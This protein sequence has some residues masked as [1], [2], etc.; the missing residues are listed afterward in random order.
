MRFDPRWI[1]GKTVRRR[2]EMKSVKGQTSGASIGFGLRKSLKLHGTD[3]DRLPESNP[4]ESSAMTSVTCNPVF[5]HRR[6]QKGAN[7]HMKSAIASVIL[8]LGSTLNAQ[9]AAPQPAPQTAP[10]AAPQ[11]CLIVT[12]AEGHRFRNAMIAGVLTGGIG[13]AAGAAFSGGRYEYRD[14][15]NLPPD[16][17][18]QKYKGPELQKLQQKG[19]HVIVVDKKDKT[20]AE[21]HDARQACMGAPA[22]PAAA[23]A[24][25]VAPA[26]APVQAAQS[27]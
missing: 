22:A 23:P 13:L 8:V 11:P 19:I 26:P 20:G 14:G 16:D 1:I 6:L 12:S 4:R 2:V 15:V 5:Q 18:K 9:Q 27:N 21:V 24:A 3:S 17:F 7:Q 25:A 10:Q